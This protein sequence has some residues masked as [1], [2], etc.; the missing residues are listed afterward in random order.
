MPKRKASVQTEVL[1]VPANFD[2]GSVLPLHLSRYAKHAYR[3]LHLIRQEVAN[4]RADNDGFVRLK[5]L[6]LRLSIP[7]RVITR[8]RAALVAARVIDHDHKFKVGHKS[9]GYR[10]CP[11]YLKDVRTIEYKT[12]R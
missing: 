7:D 11:G 12:A 1:S 6:Y 3:L 10:I 5:S 8:L 2:P 9:Q 4:G